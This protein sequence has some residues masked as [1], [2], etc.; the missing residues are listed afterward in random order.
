MHLVPCNEGCWLE[1]ILASED[2]AETGC[3]STSSVQTSVTG[4]SCSKCAAIAGSG[5]RV[6]LVT[7]LVRDGE[8]YSPSDE[9]RSGH[10]CTAHGYAVG[11]QHAKPE[12]YSTTPSISLLPINSIGQAMP[13]HSTKQYVLQGHPFLMSWLPGTD[14]YAASAFGHFWIINAWRNELLGCWH[15][16]GTCLVPVTVMSAFPQDKRFRRH[17]PSGCKA[18][19]FSPDRSSLVWVDDSQYTIAFFGPLAE[20]AAAGCRKDLPL[21][22]P[23]I[24]QGMTCKKILQSS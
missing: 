1:H 9:R 17:C 19:S 15:M 11:F 24:H 2:P 4:V 12:A 6:I 20:V 8:S 16:A 22:Q 18:L 14:I 5:S 21:A 23:L 3:I 10:L 7:L 13:H